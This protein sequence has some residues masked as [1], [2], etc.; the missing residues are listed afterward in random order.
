M[1]PLMAAALLNTTCAGHTQDRNTIA[2]HTANT[3][4]AVSGTDQLLRDRSR[5]GRETTLLE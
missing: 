5:D 2:I 4:V 3:S 1:L